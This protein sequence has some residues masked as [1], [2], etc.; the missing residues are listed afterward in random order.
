MQIQKIVGN[1]AAG[2]PHS[3]YLPTMRLFFRV[4]L[5]LLFL[6]VLL[7]K[8]E[9][10][11]NSLQLFDVETWYD[12]HISI[13]SEGEIYLA[14]ELKYPQNNYERGSYLIKI[15]SC[16]QIAW[17]KIF[18]KGN[19]SLNVHDLI[20]LENEDVL[21]MGITG[22]K[23]IFLIR[24]NPDGEQIF[25]RT[26]AY[27]THNFNYS[28]DSRSNRIMIFGNNFFSGGP[29]RNFLLI[30]DENGEIIWAK[31]YLQSTVSGEALYCTDGGFLCHSGNVIYKTDQDG[32][33]LWAKEYTF[34]DPVASGFSNMV[35]GDFQSYYLTFLKGGLHYPMKLNASGEIEWVGQGVKASLVPGHLIINDQSLIWTNS[36]PD[37]EGRLVPI[38]T[39]FSASGMVSRQLCLNHPDLSSINHPESILLPGGNAVAV[40]G[41]KEGDTY[42]DL[43]LRST[44][45]EG[46]CHLENYIEIFP[47]ATP[48]APDDILFGVIDAG[49]S[50]QPIQTLNISDLEFAQS[51]LCNTLANA[52]QQVIDTFLLCGESLDFSSPYEGYQH[53]WSDGYSGKDRFFD[54]PG[55]YTL[56]LLACEEGFE[57]QFNIDKQPCQCDTR[58]PTAFTPNGDGLNDQFTAVAE[59]GFEEYYLE[60]F[61]RWGRS[62]FSSNNPANGW[63]GTLQGKALNPEVYI[64]ICRYLSDNGIGTARLQTVSG[65]ILL[66]R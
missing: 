50:S 43:Y 10:Q 64:Y 45:D 47:S 20:V 15:D 16:N 9:S 54:E 26:Y 24:V 4:S 1:F 40:F 8:A 49:F 18:Q 14:S 42:Q 38:I 61:D 13:S 51:T 48:V 12:N 57:I 33:F 28:V 59:C 22:Q 2:P 63:D 60:V 56:Q 46:I 41:T 62:V 17:K 37:V 3:G 35:E 31:N 55:N 58:F 19:Y 5:S 65:E 6:T 44:L 52:Q 34:L 11:I 7:P 39:E 36:M 23:E 29:T 32:N 66:L 21:I 30:L 53:I 27:S 25:A